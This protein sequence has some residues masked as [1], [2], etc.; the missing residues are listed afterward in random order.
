METY[1]LNTNS[2]LLIA[3]DEYMGYINADWWETIMQWNV[4][5]CRT[6]TDFIINRIL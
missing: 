1:I 3:E 2:H 4:V 6:V 5:D